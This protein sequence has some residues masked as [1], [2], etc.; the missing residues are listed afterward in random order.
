MLLKVLIY[1]VGARD[2]NWKSFD[3]RL[4]D[5]VTRGTLR[6]GETLDGVEFIDDPTQAIERVRL[7]LESL[8]NCPSAVSSARKVL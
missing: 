3:R 1:L 7:G 6:S 5:M 4:A 2:V 8:A